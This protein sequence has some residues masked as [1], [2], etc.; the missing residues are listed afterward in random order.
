MINT[1][2]TKSDSTTEDVHIIPQP[3]NVQLLPGHFEIT[4]QTKIVSSTAYC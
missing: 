4:A 3:Q 2:N 1:Y